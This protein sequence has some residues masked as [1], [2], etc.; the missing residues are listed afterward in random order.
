[1]GRG[2]IPNEPHLLVVPNSLVSQWH[3]ELKTFFCPHS[4][5]IFRVPSVQKTLKQFW[6]K[7]DESKHDPIFR[8]AIIPH[9]V[10]TLFQYLTPIETPARSFKR[11]PEVRSTAE[12]Q[13]LEEMLLITHDPF[14]LDR[15]CRYQSSQETGVQAG[16]TRHTTSVV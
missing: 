1:M 10:S 16:W 11:W 5:D 13:G 15:R 6:E 9:S 8:I 3:R 2:P 7:F 12:A 14:D 4:V